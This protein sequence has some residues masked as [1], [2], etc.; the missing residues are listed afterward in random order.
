M[1]QWSH[2]AGD[3]R[4]RVLHSTEKTKLSLEKEHRLFMVLDTRSLVTDLR[5]LK[6]SLPFTGHLKG[7]VLLYAVSEEHLRKTPGTVWI[8]G[9]VSVLSFG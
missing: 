5:R 9:D 8:Y 4:S 3:H 6:V 7:V 1:G 2:V